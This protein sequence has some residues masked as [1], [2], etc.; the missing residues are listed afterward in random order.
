MRNGLARCGTVRLFSPFWV[1][2]GPFRLEN[3]SG[4]VSRSCPFRNGFTVPERFDTNRSGT[5]FFNSNFHLFVPQQICAFR[6]SLLCS[7]TIYNRKCCCGTEMRWFLFRN[8]RFCSGT[9]FPFCDGINNS[10]PFRNRKWCQ[11]LRNSLE[12]QQNRNTVAEQ[13]YCCRTGNTVPEQKCDGFLFRNSISVPQWFGPVV[14]VAEQ[15]KQFRNRQFFNSFY[16]KRKP[17][18]NE[19]FLTVFL[20]SFCHFLFRNE[21]WKNCSGTVFSP[22][23]SA[24][25]FFRSAMVFPFRNGFCC[26]ATVCAVPVPEQGFCSGM[27]FSK[28]LFPWTVPEQKTV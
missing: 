8:K 16:C 7:A 1:H 3:C 11:L 5:V 26:S 25:V 22:F 10:I 9:V 20:N 27:V 17:F 15:F 4:T 12:T 24:T 2:P 28:K 13:K 6:N 14:T 19:R 21:K 18:R 23:C